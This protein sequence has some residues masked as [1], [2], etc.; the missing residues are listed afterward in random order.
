M[1]FDKTAPTLSNV[2]IAS[3]NSTY[4]FILNTNIANPTQAKLGDII[5]LTFTAS[6]TIQT[7]TVIFKSGGNPITDT[8]ISYN[9]TTGI[10]TWTAEYTAISDT[11]GLVTYTISYSDLAGNGIVTN[12]SGVTFDKTPPT[13]SSV[14]IESNNTNNSTTLAKV[15]DNII[16][17]FTAS[18]TIQTPTVIF[19]SGG[20]AINDTTISYNNIPGT[21]TWTA[22]YT[23]QSSDTNGTVTYSISYSDLA[24]NAGS[25]VT[26]GSGSVHL[27]KHHQQSRVSLLTHLP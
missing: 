10:N 9:N 26:S 7:P 3:N 2:S 23:A 16:L 27:I 4:N 25:S 1:R 19:Q 18:E 8:T 22:Q 17:T 24:G 11:N 5:T 21:N 6:E 15:G 20:D 13:L 14:S 12:G